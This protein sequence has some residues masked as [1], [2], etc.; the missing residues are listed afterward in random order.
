MEEGLSHGTGSG[1]FHRFLRHENMSALTLNGP[2]V[3]S[4]TRIS[5]L[6]E[7]ERRVVQGRLSVPHVKFSLTPEEVRAGVV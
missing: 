5:V 7:L 1:C 4:S 6:L 3:L 2:M